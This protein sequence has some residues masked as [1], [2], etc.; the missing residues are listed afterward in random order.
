[1]VTEWQ[2]SLLPLHNE[3]KKNSVE[4]AATNFDLKYTTIQY[5]VK[6]VVENSVSCERG[7]DH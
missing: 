3:P 1:M 6:E 2:L 7:V 4:E 5:L